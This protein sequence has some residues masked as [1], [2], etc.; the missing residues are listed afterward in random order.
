MRTAASIAPHAMQSRDAGPAT[1]DLARL[2]FEDMAD[3]LRKMATSK[4]W[5]LEACSSGPKKRP[6]H[7]LDIQR[8]HLKVLQQ[9]AA[10][11]QRAATRPAMRGAEE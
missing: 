1:E 11:Y 9:A 6:D 8:K 3:D 10:D 2:S 4:T 7:E 5:W